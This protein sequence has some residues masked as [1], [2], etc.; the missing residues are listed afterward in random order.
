MREETTLKN[1]MQFIMKNILVS[2]VVIGQIHQTNTHQ[3]VVFQLERPML[4]K[5]P[6]TWD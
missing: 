1:E 4:K 2:L 6:E 3:Q 5:E